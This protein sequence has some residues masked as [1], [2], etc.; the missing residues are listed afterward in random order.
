MAKKTGAPKAPR[1]KKPRKSKSYAPRRAQV[2]GV[3]SV[4]I[5]E[6]VPVPYWVVGSSDWIDNWFDLDA[7]PEGR[8]LRV[9]SSGD[10]GQIKEELSKEPI[11][12]LDTETGQ[13]VNTRADAS[14]FDKVWG[15]EPWMPTS[16]VLMAQYGT[17]RRP[18][19]L[20]P[21][22]LGE[23][24]CFL[25]SD[26]FLKILQNSVF[27]FKFL[28][29]KHA[30][31]LVRIYD[32]MLAEQVLTAGRPGLKVTLLDLARRYAP[33]RIIRKDVR[34]E[35]VTFKIGIQKFS[36]EMT[37]YSGRDIVLP[38]DIM[39]GQVP[40]LRKW[41]LEDVAKAEF[42]CVPCTAEMEL[43]GVHLD[44]D[45][46]ELALTA[47]REDDI[48]LREKIMAAV[49]SSLADAGHSMG[50]FG[51]EG[52][53]FDLKSIPERLRIFR[54]LLGFDMEDATRESML[55]I[56]HE[57][58]QDI[59]KWT[60][61]DKVLTTYGDGLIKKISP[62]DGRFHPR[63]SQLGLGDQEA[64][65]GKKTNIATGRYSSN[66]Q[67]LPKPIERFAKVADLG[68]Q[69]MIN[70]TFEAQIA[71]IRQQRGLLHAAA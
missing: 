49:G 46:L 62:Y 27:D 69:G 44:G 18:L 59:A 39:A 33:Y 60:A 25:E 40:E 13:D 47:Y 32:T 22:L 9:S 50:L 55:N 61:V 42:E 11:H 64:R 54:D 45:I 35:F 17:A 56:P 53:S 36:K 68:E 5:E 10:L 66:F 63:F 41:K 7:L 51:Q 2:S 31:H 48:E 71:Q 21:R 15:M 23:L 37:D 20:E 16:Q 24:R 67:Q 26:Q 57:A 12:T 3:H 29:K 8:V 19:I 30:V 65:S 52:F 6:E 34:D 1:I 14:E 28:L 38:P 70:A 58:A 4:A 43:F